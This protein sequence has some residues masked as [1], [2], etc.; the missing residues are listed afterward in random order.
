MSEILGHID[1]ALGVVALALIVTSLLWI[2]KFPDDDDEY[3]RN[4]LF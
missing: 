2:Y 1:Y 3:R 4:N